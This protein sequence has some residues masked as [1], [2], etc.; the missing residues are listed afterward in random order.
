M[1]E[2]IFFGNHV[3]MYIY[4]FPA[5]NTNMKDFTTVHIPFSTFLIF[6]YTSVTYLMFIVYIVCKAHS[7]N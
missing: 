2:N 5:G 1:I 6:L 3:V 4:L 7:R